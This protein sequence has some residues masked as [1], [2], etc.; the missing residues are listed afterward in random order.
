MSQTYELAAAR[1]DRIGKGA[2]RATR[3]DGMIP[4]V[5][6]GGGEP[7]VPIKVDYR[8][9]DAKIR[10]GGFL[11][12]VATID[13]DGAKIRVLPRDFQ[14]DPV[15]DL[16][17]HVDFLRVKPGTRVRVDVPVRFINESAAPGIK[18]GGVL[19]IVRHAIELDCSADAIPT[20]ITIDLSG[21]EINDSVH[22]SE[23][24]LP[25]GTKPTITRNFTVATIGAPAAVKD[26]ARAAA[27][28]A[29]AA[30]LAPPVEGE[31]GAEAAAAPAEGEAPA[32]GAEAAKG[33][34]AGKPGA[35]PAAPAAKAAPAAP[36]K[37]E[38]GK[39]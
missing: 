1:R 28:A 8:T 11:T 6:Y 27:E 35:A 37:K 38:G 21:L 36:A 32:A 9:L 15:K 25:E 7:P 34:E 30:A 4:G 31:E 19:N 17:I 16:A 39:K 2:A 29:A 33:V 24:T 26:E 22:I 20:H 5:I 13:V 12:T 14:L 10:G 23:V 3:R 18:R